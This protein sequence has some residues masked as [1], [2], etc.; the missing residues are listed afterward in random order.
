[1][2]LVTF[3]GEILTGKLPFLYSVNPYDL[4]DNHLELI[5]SIVCLVLSYSTYLSHKN[6]TIDTQDIKIIRIIYL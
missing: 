6:L 2:D 3:T 5:Q 1:M 4:M